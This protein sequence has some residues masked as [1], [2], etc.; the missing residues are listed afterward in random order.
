MFLYKEIMTEVLTVIVFGPEKTTTIGAYQSYL[1]VV[2]YQMFG[3]VGLENNGLCGKPKVKVKCMTLGHVRST[4]NEAEDYSPFT[5]DFIDS[6][7]QPTNFM[8]EN[9]AFLQIIYSGTGSTSVVAVSEEDI[10]ES[11]PYICLVDAYYNLEN[12]IARSHDFL[13]VNV[14]GFDARGNNNVP[15]FINFDSEYSVMMGETLTG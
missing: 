1:D 11:Y 5:L 4:I 13:K 7:Y 15:E 2:L 8:L 14:L 10:W 3:F 12:L 6:I 9:P